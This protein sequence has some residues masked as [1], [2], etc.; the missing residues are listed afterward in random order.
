MRIVNSIRF[1]IIS[2]L[3]IATLYISASVSVYGATGINQIIN[4]QG[5]VV[6]TD[7]TNVTDGTYDFTVKLYD[8]AASGSSNTYTETWSSAAL[9]SSTMS[10][11]PTSGGESLT[12]S[13]NTNEST[14]KVGQLI[15]NT[16]K[17]EAVTVTS[18]NTGTNVMGISP[19]RQAWANGD[20]ITNKIYVKDGVFKIAINSLNQ[21]LSA[22]DFNSDSIFMGVNFNADGEMK[23]RIRFTATPYAFNA[24]KVNGLTVTA[25][26]GTLT[27]PNST[28][29]AFSG[30]NNATFTTIGTT[31]LTLP[32]GGT[33]ATLAGTETFTSKTIGSTGLTFS[34]ASSDITTGSNEHLALMP[35]GTGSVGIGTTN[36]LAKLDVNGTASVSGNLSFA[37]GVR[38]IGSTS[39][40]DL[41]FGDSSTGNLT[42]QPRGSAAI[43]QVQIGAGGAGSTTPDYFALD[44]KS[45]TGDPSGGFEGAMYYNTFDNKFRCYQGSAWTDCIGTGGAGPWTDGTGISYLTDTAEDFAVGGSSLASPLSVDVSLNTTRLG[46][47]SSSNAVLGMYASNGSTGT[48]TYTTDDLWSFEGG[49][50]GIGTT[51]PN[52]KLNIAA[53]S[54]SE[55]LFNI[56]SAL[57]GI[58]AVSV[59]S[60]AP[61]IG[62]GDTNLQTNHTYIGISDTVKTIALNSSELIQLGDIEQ[63]VNNT[64]L[65][66]DTLNS[67]FT[68][69]NGTVGIGT[70]SPTTYFHVTG[71]KVGKALSIFDE[72]GDQA[73]LTASASGVTKFLVDHSGNVGIGTTA[74]LGALDVRGNIYMN[75]GG[76]TGSPVLSFWND[77]NTGLYRNSNDVLSFV[78]NGQPGLTLDGT[79][80]VGRF[81]VGARNSQPVSR[82]QLIDDNNNTASGLTF[83]ESASTYMQIY[84]SGSN[85]LNISGGNVGIGTTNPIEVLDIVGNATISGNLVFDSGTRSIAG[86]AFNTL[87]IGDS[88][89]GNLSLQP[90]GTSI[91]G[92]VQIGA[93]AGGSTTPDLLALDI[94]SD[95]G[96]PT[97]MNG[98]IY[99]NA[100][101]SKFRCYQGGAWADCI[102][103]GSDTDKI[104]FLPWSPYNSTTPVTNLTVTGIGCMA[105]TNMSAV[106]SKGGT[107][108]V[109]MDT[110]SNVILRY[111]GSVTGAQTGTVTVRLRNY[112][113]AT[114]TVTTTFNSNTTCTDR[115]SANTD[116]SALTGIKVFG[117]QIGDATTTDDPGLSGVVVEFSK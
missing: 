23:P 1:L 108:A 78:A 21:D 73:L 35:N 69:T 77:T 82:L 34:G 14:I 90:K 85:K 103:A 66:I 101:S 25:T 100:N 5:K 27:I 95:A 99:Y 80:G 105:T 71:A 28:T 86:R 91:T 6:N 55:V 7:G 56:S 102:A 110:Y 89:T 24:Q 98:A 52:G 36:P 97:G 67:K 48:V 15:W 41:I 51:V 32:T 115:S 46:S 114:D 53:G 39:M 84:K 104:T 19:T 9:W 3:V 10:S 117:L 109:D 113:D 16:T 107:F 83:G 17:G 38:T 40:N 57:T 43:G 49:S 111:S 37:G 26:T 112:T 96:D 64:L 70:T 11:A 13:S 68:F 94:K 22:V 54:T 50:I 47:G 61:N 76:S 8:G 106:G 65:N 42:L 93:G 79:A 81:I 60:N 20:T 87:T 72:T 4:F 44:V 92:N 62:M 29:I 58:F 30:S 63:D 45:S 75:D 12:Y 88:Q 18:V 74:P 59:V 33:L 31:A 116:I 2:L